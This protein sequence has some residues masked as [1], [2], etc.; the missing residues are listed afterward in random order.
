MDTSRNFYLMWAYWQS[1]FTLSI[2]RKYWQYK[3]VLLR[4]DKKK[5]NIVYIQY[6]NKYRHITSCLLQNNANNA[7]KISYRNSAK[8]ISSHIIFAFNV[9][10][11]KKETLQSQYP[12]HDTRLSNLETFTN[13]RG[14]WSV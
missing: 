10:Y 8:K 6:Y 11:S 1:C 2:T 9:F 4:K 14:R 7:I 12:T 5:G 3:Q 13:S